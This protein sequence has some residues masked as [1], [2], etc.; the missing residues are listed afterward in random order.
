MENTHSYSPIHPRPTLK[1]RP[2]ARR[3]ASPPRH[4]APEINPTHAKRLRF[5]TAWRALEWLSATF[6]AINLENPVPLVL[7]A[8]KMVQAAPHPGISNKC[9]RLAMRL[10]ASRIV[11]R[12]AVAAEGSIRHDL[13]GVAVRLVSDE[14]REHARSRL[15]KHLA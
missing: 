12:R 7:G 8:L 3:R 10:Y 15:P 9:L 13:R 6:P 5:E 1:L 2:N 11:Y 14:H 4:R